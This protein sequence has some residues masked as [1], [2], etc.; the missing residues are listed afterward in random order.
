MI[1]SVGHSSTQFT[2]GTSNLAGYG[3]CSS[4]DNQPNPRLPVRPAPPY[5]RSHAKTA[6]KTSQDGEL[7]IL[8]FSLVQCLLIG[9]QYF[10]NIQTVI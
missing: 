7:N 6:L 3:G 2:F 5:S 9:Y 4:V 8:I 10:F 1:E